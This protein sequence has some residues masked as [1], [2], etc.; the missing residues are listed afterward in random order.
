MAASYMDD[1]RSDVPRSAASWVRPEKLHLTLRFIG[2]CS[3]ACLRLL[4]EQVAGIAAVTSPFSLAITGTGVFPSIKGPRVVWLGVRDLKGALDA[5]QRR[6]V[7]ADHVTTAT[8]R[9]EQR[10]SPHLTVARI[11]DMEKCRAMIAR[12]LGSVFESPDFRVS[13]IIICQSTLHAAGSIYQVRSIHP[14]TGV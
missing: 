4:T 1:L 14:L 10:F 11:K 2:D 7:P 9:K 12:H 13:E 5:I 6:L 8:T 3:D